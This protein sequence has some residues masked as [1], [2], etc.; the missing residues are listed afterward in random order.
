[1]LKKLLFL[2]LI[3][4]LPA[5]LFA[6]TTG[7]IVGKVTDKE[8]GGS[9]PGA[10]VVIEGTLLGAATDVDGRFIILNVPVGTYSLK[11]RFIGYRDVTVQNIRVHAGL[12]AEV[13]FAMP[14]EVLVLLWK[15]TQQIQ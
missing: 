2:T 12:T 4:L 10:N 6:A 13:N 11:A 1:M 8:M 3:V 14:S 9:L 15:R 7:K 5:S